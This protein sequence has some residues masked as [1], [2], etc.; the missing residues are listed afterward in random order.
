MIKKF[1][2][3]LLFLAFLSI[4]RVYASDA[5]EWA[6]TADVT[7]L[8]DSLSV[9]LQGA[10]WDQVFQSGHS[11]ALVSRWLHY[12]GGGEFDGLTVLEGMI[13]RGEVGSILVVNLG[14]NGGVTEEELEMVV[15]R[16][17]GLVDRLVF[18]TTN[19]NVGHRD[20][21]QDLMWQ[22]ANKYPHVYVLDWRA[23]S[24][25]VGRGQFY[26]GDDIHLSNYGAFLDY[27]VEG[28]FEVSQGV[29]PRVRRVVE[30]A[31]ETQDEVVNEVVVESET[32][33]EELEPTRGRVNL[34]IGSEKL[35]HL[36]KLLKNA[37]EK[38]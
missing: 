6:K 11:N 27:L 29:E 15:S 32:T 14:T 37:L 2:H 30:S 17:R 28:L 26:S 1:V 16:T 38:R 19:S 25:E 12:T 31:D 36:L 23:Y 10:G 20:S 4:P 33:S 7:L 22:V 24:D 34:D 3:L 5:Y 8:G 13:S 18:V 35:E 9:G 21:V